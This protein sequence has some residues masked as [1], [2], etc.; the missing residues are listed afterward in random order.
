MSPQWFSKKKNVALLASSGA[1]VEGKGPA[2]PDAILRR[3]EQWQARVL[4]LATNIPES[5]GAI[6]LI[7]NTMSMVDLTVTGMKKPD[8]AVVE[9]MLAKFDL[10][11]AGMLEWLV[12]EY[13]PS[14]T[15][16]PTTKEIEWD[17]Y[18]PVELR[19][20]NQRDAQILS[21]N[22]KYLPLDASAKWYRTW[23]PDPAKR[24]MA[25]SPHKGMVDLM[26]AMYVHQLADTAVA[27]SRLAGAGILYWPTNLPSM[28]LKDGYPEPGSQEELQAMLTKA[29]MDTIDNRNS[30][31][32][33]V[34]VIAFG[35][36][37]QAGMEPKHILLERPDNSH[38]F[39]E[40]MNQYAT[41]YARGVE[42]P[43]EAVQ[44]IG[45]ANHWTAWVIK[46][47]K[48]KFYIYP[49]V[50]N[51]AKGLQKNFVLPMAKILGYSEE[52]MKKIKVVPDGSRLIEKP[53]KS[54]AAI[55]L[56]QLGGFLSDDAVLIETGFDPATEA[57]SVDE[58]AAAAA[59]NAARIQQ[60]PAQYNEQSNMGNK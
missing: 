7:H 20:K 32:A 52:D 34:P 49:I 28:P 14:W 42:L 15:I 39:A 33:V 44:G 17:I 27:T 5:S 26:D 16:D 54:D 6:A 12:G 21:A 57:A 24:F 60:M 53:D 56:A 13:Y 23:K 50:N 19:V 58:K 45:Q 11:R 18:S 29:M 9:A 43:I 10:G 30:A 2:T 48:W 51:A 37:D 55:R 35:D 59:K 8:T 1:V 41:R 4:Q 25:W 31:D 47:E 38:A 40:R 22:D 46:E 36:I 3:S